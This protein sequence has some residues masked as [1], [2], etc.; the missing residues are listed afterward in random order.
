MGRRLPN[1]N[2]R[3]WSN[4]KCD[5]ICKVE[6][7][8]RPLR[9][10]NCHD[11]SVVVCFQRERETFGGFNVVAAF[12]RWWFYELCVEKNDRSKTYAKEGVFVVLTWWVSRGG[13]ISGMNVVHRMEM[14]FIGGCRWGRRTKMQMLWSGFVGWFKAVERKHEVGVAE[15]T[16]EVISWWWRWWCGLEVWR[17]LMLM[18]DTFVVYWYG[19]CRLMKF[20]CWMKKV[21]RVVQVWCLYEEGCVEGFLWGKEERGSEKE[22]EQ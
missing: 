19:C 10:H 12:W 8:R 11:T 16:M 5:R 15:S 9:S 21:V 3:C 14:C 6:G 20:V 4:N 13:D 22:D 18:W 7:F 2:A 17:E 1:R